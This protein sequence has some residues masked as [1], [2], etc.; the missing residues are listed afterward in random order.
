MLA[1]LQHS[2]SE[3]L[4]LRNTLSYESG[5]DLCH[6]TEFPHISFHCHNGPFTKGKHAGVKEDQ[7]E[8][9]AVAYHALC[10]RFGPQRKK[11]VPK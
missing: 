2:F 6:T 11:V 8:A 10:A 9:K 1:W 3:L 5:A 7:C 4:A